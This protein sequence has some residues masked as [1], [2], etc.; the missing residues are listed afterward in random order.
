M[1]RHTSTMCLRLI[2]LGGPM[3]VFSYAELSL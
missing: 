1:K 3:L 2:A